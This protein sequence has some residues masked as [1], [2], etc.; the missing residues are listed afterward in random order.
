M[1]I[2]SRLRTVSDRDGAVV[3]DFDSDIRSTLN[4]TG[5]FV[6]QRLQRGMPIAQIVTELASESNTEEREVSRDVSEFLEELRSNGLLT[7]S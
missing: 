2:S 4:S 3:I 5:A 6:W 7:R 1:Q